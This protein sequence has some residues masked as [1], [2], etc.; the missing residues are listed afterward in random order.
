MVDF[1]GVYDKAVPHDMCQKM[2]NYF[3]DNRNLQFRGRFI[4]DGEI[5]RL[6]EV[7]DSI[8]MTLDLFDG[9]APSAILRNIIEFYT[10]QYVHKYKSTFVVSSF[11]A[12]KD[13]N[14]QRY[15]PGQ[16]YHALHLSLIHI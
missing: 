8:D 6:P 14:I 2:I 3:E 16:G 13:Y 11:S 4:K 7:K 15:N 1:I 9:I 10:D 12:E 5:Q